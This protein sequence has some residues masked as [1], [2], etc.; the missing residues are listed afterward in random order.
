MF[1]LRKIHL[2]QITWYG[3]VTHTMHN[4]YIKPNL[5]RAL[6]KGVVSSFFLLFFLPTTYKGHSVFE[7][8]RYFSLIPY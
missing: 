6:L 4:F 3:L 2:V 5:P 1:F 8:G 7:E